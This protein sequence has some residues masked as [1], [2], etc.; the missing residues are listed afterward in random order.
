[1]WYILI[2]LFLI[3]GGASGQFALRGTNSYTALVVIG[4]IVAGYGVYKMAVKAKQDSGE[5]PVEEDCIV[6][7]EK[8]IVYNQSHE[9]SGILQELQ[10]GSKFL[11]DMK[12]N[13]DRFYQIRLP[14]GMTGYIINTSKYIRNSQFTND[15]I[16]LSP[17]NEIVTEVLNEQ[18]EQENEE[19]ETQVEDPKK[20]PGCGCQID[21]N[22]V[23]CPDCGLR[24]KFQD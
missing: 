19:I 23:E 18:N 24:L 5:E 12:N 3:I 6:I 16:I 17:Q 10:I 8:M 22:T 15:Q 11:M 13:F 9:S 4:V 21:E 14:N 1:M 7:D 20:C 2:G